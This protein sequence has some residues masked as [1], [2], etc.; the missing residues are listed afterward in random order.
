METQTSD[1]EG[2]CQISTLIQQQANLN[3]E[4]QKGENES[5]NNG[6]SSCNFSLLVKDGPTKYEAQA[7]RDD[8]ATI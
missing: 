7:D 5:K 2:E 8:G 1:S 4:A 6:E 3:H